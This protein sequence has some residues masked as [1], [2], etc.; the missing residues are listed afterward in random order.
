[1]QTNLNIKQKN[2]KN[3]KKNK[4]NQPVFLC[5]FPGYVKNSAENGVSDMTTIADIDEHGISLN[6][7]VR[8][9]QDNI[10]VSLTN[11]NFFYL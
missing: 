7:K 8:Y 4:K 1:M 2:P 10:Y 5:T 11:L 6:L 3:K 9:Q